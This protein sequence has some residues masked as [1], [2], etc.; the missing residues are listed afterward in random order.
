MYNQFWTSGGC[1][2]SK[3]Y[4]WL[5]L[6]RDFFTQPKIKK[7][8]RIAGGDTYT[9]IYLK[10]MLLSLEN[11]GVLGFEGIEG[12]FPEEI[13]LTIDE[14]PDNVNVAINYLFTQNLIEEISP[15]NFLMVQAVDMTGNETD[16]AIRMRRLRENRKEVVG[17]LEKTSRCDNDVTASNTLV[18]SCDTD[19]K[20]KKEKDIEKDSESR[21]QKDY[22][23][24]ADMYNDTCVSFPHLTK[25]SDRRRKAIRA[26]LK[27]GYT[28]DDFQ[29]LFELAE[30]SEFLKGSNGRNWSATFDWLIQ[31]GNM[32]KVLDGNYQSRE[33]MQKGEKNNEKS[34]N[35]YSV[36]LW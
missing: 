31:D 26:R 32:A 2:L 17:K 24:I 3:K 25:L 35:S 29:R 33:P 18:I 27:A 21:A 13:A 4:Y 8:R 28:L 5:K 10:M 15:N 20:K 1:E 34:E 19:K 30:S 9:I 14:D 23:Q 36:K 7:L 22:Q 11:D 6:K 12:T 16:S